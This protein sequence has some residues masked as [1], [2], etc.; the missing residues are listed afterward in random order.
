MKEK[1]PQTTKIQKTTSLE[2][3]FFYTYFYK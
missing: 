1:S 2:A 3:A